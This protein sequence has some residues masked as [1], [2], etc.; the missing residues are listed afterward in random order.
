MYT[1][2]IRQLTRKKIIG[3]RIKSSVA[4]DKTV[5]LWR[6]FMP[7]RNEIQQ[8]VS[9]DFFSMQVYPP[10]FNF[11]NLDVTTEFEKRAGVEVHNFDEVP[12]D[13]ETFV[14]DEGLYAVF[15]YKGNSNQA[16]SFFQYIFTRWL[17]S[18]GYDLDNRVHFEILG[19][20]YKNNDSESEE[21]V[22]IPIRTKE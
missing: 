8:K 20:K 21:E 4:N 7:R 14:I 3:M 17:P 10:N 2:T 6:G 13:M 19:E 9:S 12:V 16:A 11:Q 1:P 5:E 22:W 15:N 18:S